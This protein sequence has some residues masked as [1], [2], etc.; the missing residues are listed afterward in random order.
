MPIIFKD[1]SDEI[2]FNYLDQL[3]DNSI[4]LR[5]K[6]EPAYKVNVALLHLYGFYKHS[7]YESYKET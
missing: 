5:I 3:P 2:E 4:T 7:I 6:G 1:L